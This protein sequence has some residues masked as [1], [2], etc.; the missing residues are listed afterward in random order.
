FY[1]ISISDDCITPKWS[2]IHFVTGEVRKKNSY[3]DTLTNMGP[4]KIIQTLLKIKKYNVRCV[5]SNGPGISV[6]TALFFKV[7]GAKI[8]HVETW[9]R[10][11]SKSLTGMAM[12]YIADVFYVQNKELCKIYKNAIYSGRL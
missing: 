12:Y 6:I 1:I 7:F 2:H 4:I 3:F 10:F 5:I 9:S 8:I 11:V